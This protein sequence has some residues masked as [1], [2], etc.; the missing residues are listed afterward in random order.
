MHKGD[1]LPK[2]A[3]AR[4]AADPQA[5]LL[6]VRTGPEWTFVGSP[7]VDRLLRISWQTFPTMEVN[8]RFAASVSEAGVPKSAPIFCICRSGSRS[9]Q[10]ASALTAAGFSSCFNVAQG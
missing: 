6:D 2:E 8:A 5:V 3:F 7:A 1:I 10:A 4:L 9:A